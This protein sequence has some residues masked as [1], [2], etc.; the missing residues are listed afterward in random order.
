MIRARVLVGLSAG[1]VF[2]SFASVIIKVTPAPSIMIAA[3]R[4]AIAALVL[5]PLFWTRPAQRRAELSRVPLWPIVLSGLLLAAHFALWIESLNRTSV[6]SSV[7]LVAMNPIFVAALSPLVLREKVSWR[8]VLAV[9]LGVLGAAIIASPVLKSPGATTGNLLAVA[10]AVCAGGYLMAGRS[11]R[12]KLPLVTYVYVVY[13][14]ATVLLVVVM[15]AERAW[16]S[17]PKAWLFVILLGLGPQLLGHTS[18][19]W[20]LKYAPAPAVAMAVLGEPVGTTLLAWGLLRQVPTSYE[21]AGGTV[22]CAAIYLAVVDV[23]KA[24]EPAG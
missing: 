3:G 11:V 24:V 17:N 16:V 6:A 18:F 14:I 21:F 10:G 9:V 22:I 8:M 15:L 5:S 20:A 23:Q 13:S 4:L 19:N 1:I 2:L 12:P 7:V